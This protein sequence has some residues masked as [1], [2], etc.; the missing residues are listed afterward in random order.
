MSAEPDDLLI[1][2][3]LLVAKSALLRAQ[4]RSEVAALRSRSAIGLPLAGLS[5]LLGG[6]AGGAGWL[7]KVGGMLAIARM[8]LA[9]IGRFRK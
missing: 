7:G 9:V 8:V 5:L 2:K 4:L 1:R 6:R 3:Q